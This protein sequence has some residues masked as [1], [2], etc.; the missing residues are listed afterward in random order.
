MLCTHKTASSASLVIQKFVPTLLTHISP[1]SRPFLVGIVSLLS[2]TI[3]SEI[4]QKITKWIF[5]QALFDYT[6]LVITWDP[7]EFEEN[8]NLQKYENSNGN[9]T[10]LQSNAVKQLTSLMNYMIH[11][12]KQDRPAGQ[13]YNAYY[14][15]LDEQWF[16]QTVHD[17][18]S[19]LVNAVLENDRSQTTPGTA[20]PLSTSPS[21]SMRSPIYTELASFKRSIKREASSYST[22]YFDKFQ[23]DLFIT[24]KSH[25]VSEI[26]DPTFT[27][28]PSPEEKELFEAKYSCI[29]SSMKLY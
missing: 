3:T 10:H 7:I 25:S 22:W 2:H 24:A 15:I 9:I 27:S 26:L 5:Y 1:N 20:M 11:L 6:N 14:F 13:R 8:R 29:K 16:S 4:G 12:I 21:P 19:T 23:R 18:R 17:M 28:G